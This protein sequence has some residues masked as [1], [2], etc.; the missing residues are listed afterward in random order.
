MLKE[1]DGVDGLDYTVEELKQM[2]PD[3]VVVMRHT[4]YI[5]RDVLCDRARSVA[6]NLDDYIQLT[7]LVD[8]LKIHRD[9]FKDRFTFMER[10]GVRLFDWITVCGIHFVRLDHE[11]KHLFQ[12]YQPF[13]ASLQDGDHVVHMKLLGDIKIGFY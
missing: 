10:S 8:R 12:N 7:E 4:S 9:L 5:Y 11:L 1:L 13:V 2:Y 6:T 3:K